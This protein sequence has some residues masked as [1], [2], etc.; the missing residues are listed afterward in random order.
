MELVEA[1]GIDTS[2][3]DCLHELREPLEVRMGSNDFHMACQNWLLF[4]APFLCIHCVQ[5]IEGL[6]GLH[7]R[8]RMP[9][10]PHF[11]RLDSTLIGIRVSP[12]TPSVCFSKNPQEEDSDGEE[13]ESV[14]WFGTSLQDRLR[15]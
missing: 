1:L 5:L 10:H 13:I 15:S 9:T 8:V 3:V 11:G 7:D 4:L 14:T 2:D 12:R 6:T